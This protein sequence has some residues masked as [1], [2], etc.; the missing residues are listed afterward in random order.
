MAF[1]LVQAP[2]ASGMFRGRP[3]Y[4]LPYPEDAKKLN[5]DGEEEEPMMEE[6]EEDEDS[7]LLE[8]LTTFPN[9]TKRKVQL[10][11]FVIVHF[12]A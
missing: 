3:G 7:T 12:F 6:E 11:R 9:R 8:K 4:V 5:E 1:L 10:T 2:K